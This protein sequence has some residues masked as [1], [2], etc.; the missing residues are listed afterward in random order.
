MPSLQQLVHEIDST[1]DALTF[2]SSEE[3]IDV[4]QGFIDDSNPNWREE[5]R[6]D[7]FDDEDD[8]IAASPGE[9]RKRG[10]DAEVDLDEYYDPELKE[11]AVK[12]VAQAVRL[13]E[14]LK[15]F[16]QYYGHEELSFILSK[17]ND[18]LHE[19]KLRAPKYQKTITDFFTS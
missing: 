19:I 10:S 18:K 14:Q 13:A 6:N 15:D 12:T 17:V 11:P 9:K 4:C 3:Q 16:A 7:L 2:I 5:V 1:C 8:E